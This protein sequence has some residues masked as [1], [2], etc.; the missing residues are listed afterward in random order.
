MKRTHLLKM[1]LVVFFL[2]SSVGFTLGQ[3]P[4]TLSYQGILSNAK[5]EVVPAGIYNIT[6]KLYTADKGG[7]PIW[8]EIQS[9]A[10]KD[11]I[12]SASLG[13]IK[14]L[15]VP[16][17]KPY[18]L[19]ITVGDGTE[20]TQRMELTASAY[21]LHA[22]S[23]AD[24]AVTGKNIAKN[25]V[26]RGINS[27]TDDVNLVAGE[28]VTITQE[29][30]SLVISANMAGKGE[31]NIDSESESLLKIAKPPKLKKTW[32]TEGNALTDPN[33]HFLGTTDSQPLVIRTDS[34]EVMRIDV[35]GNLGIGTATP[36]EKLDVNGSIAVSGTVDG[37]DISVHAADDTAHHTPPIS[38]PPSGAA[39]GDL[40]GIYPNPTVD[41]NTITSAKIVDS[42]ISTD[43][44]AND[45]VTTEKIAD[46]T[47]NT[48]DI[49]PNIV[50]SIAGVSNDGGNIAL[51]AGGSITITPNDAA[52]TILITSPVS[53][54]D[55]SNGGEAGVADRTLGN[56]D[57]FGLGLLT[58]N[59]TRLHI[60]NAGN[61]GIGTTN[62]VSQLDVA[63]T[64]QMTGFR[65]PTGAVDGYIL[66]SNPSGLASWQAPTAVPDGDWTI[67]GNN[68]FSAVNGNVG[69]G[70]NNPT[71]KLQVDGNV[72][73]NSDLDV[74][75]GTLH[76]DGTNNRVGIGTTSPETKL[77][78][79]TTSGNTYSR[80]DIDS[81]SFGGGLL[82][83]DEA[84]T[85]PVMK[86]VLQFVS[87]GHV[88]EQR[89]N[90]LEISTI[91]SPD[92]TLRP[93]DTEAMRITN[94]GNVGIGTTNP[95]SQLDVA[96]TA[97]MTGFRMPTGAVDG[98]ILTSNASGEASWQIP[99]AVSDG[100]WTISGS[101]MFSGVAGNVGI[102]T[103]TPSSNLEI[104]AG[105][106]TALDVRTT[107]PDTGGEIRFTSAAGP[108]TTSEL[109]RFQW[110]HGAIGGAG[111]I[112][113]KDGTPNSAQ[114]KFIVK[115]TDGTLV[116][117][118]RMR[119][120][121]FVSIGPNDA[122]AKLEVTSS[123]SGLTALQLSGVDNEAVS[124]AIN[125]IDEN[126]NQ[127]FWVRTQGIG[128]SSKA[129]MYLSG[130][131]G[132]GTT[133]PAIQLALGDTD[134]GLQQQGD[135]NLAI[136]TNSFERVRFSASGRVGI[137]TTSPARE[138]HIRGNTISGARIRFEDP[139]LGFHTFDIGADA[140]FRIHDIDANAFRFYIDN[141]GNIGI[142]T[143]GPTAQLHTTGSVRFANF[144]AGTLQ[145]TASGELFVSSDVRLKT[146]KGHF[147][148]GLSA[149]S[150]IE[151]IS[152]SWNQESGLETK[153]TYTGFSAQNVQD[154]I[155]EAVSEDKNGYLTLSDR[156]I[157]ATLVNA[158]KELK[159][160]NEKLKE[161]MG[162]LTS[163]KA[164]MAKLEASL[165]KMKIR[166]A[167]ADFHNHSD[168]S[169]TVS[170]T[171]RR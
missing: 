71:S 161:Q 127:M 106:G 67:S 112:A 33:I 60:Q 153:S 97:Q 16:F 24:S 61:V 169:K 117:A 147:S 6:F 73:I 4:K 131:F 76:V 7:T 68:I 160:E 40:T 109:G 148:R 58:N 70:T 170:S 77:H 47:V 107:T 125:A 105:S 19:G 32:E 162:E 78:L 69:I 133:N 124:A 130:N 50:S 136:I 94:A 128:N 29:G 26:V 91:G 42:T 157:I 25:Q 168:E 62:P 10:V 15:E 75:G 89:R 43:D 51:V 138:L 155:P 12:F 113:L 103:S 126:D 3:I 132:I 152:Y 115:N 79:Y 111:I 63:G 87:N 46:G 49:A 120:N 8:T 149:I 96:G 159:I 98:Y 171:E 121:G 150:K 143:T 86:A 102:G 119:S 83:F 13:K 108:S 163:L 139:Q 18:W 55:F 81:G 92:I 80:F 20:A 44:L 95:M 129:D 156:P 158:V 100:D 30:K 116:E 72:D 154:V 48:V 164:K 28:N 35:A 53:G 11:G 118:M 38:L 66:T 41:N 110:Y 14:P 9:I 114:F 135:G 52:N 64:A 5:G 31:G 137:G 17:D 85:T 123:A 165:G 37:V 39:G 36:G 151:P 145:T 93:N 56:T 146:I 141:S 45:A 74:D 142:G 21:S 82:F 134:T 2:I 104:E 23:I 166:T 144:G 22:Q 101:D 57:N 140:G 90:N 54:G 1:F 167:K 84:N 99:A 34:V 88:T 27:L 122:N 65:M 59:M